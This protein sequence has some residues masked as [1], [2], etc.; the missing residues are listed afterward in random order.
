MDS[1]LMDSCLFYALIILGALQ[2]EQLLNDSWR[3]ALSN[4]ELEARKLGIILV[5]VNRNSFLNQILFETLFLYLD[6][7]THFKCRFKISSEIVFRQGSYNL[8]ENWVWL[9]ALRNN[10]MLCAANVVKYE[11]QSTIQE[12]L[13]NNVELESK[14]PLELTIYRKQGWEERRKG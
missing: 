1:Y 8:F 12:L 6:Q 9:N 11:A 5:S 10:Q 2:H 4:L 14:Q 3:H 7:K 13:A